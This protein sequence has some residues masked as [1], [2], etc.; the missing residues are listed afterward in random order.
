MFL[1]AV[2]VIYLL[3]FTAAEYYVCL[4]HNVLVYIYDVNKS[5]IPNKN[6][7]TIINEK[8]ITK[9]TPQYRKYTVSCIAITLP[10][11][12]Y[13]IRDF[14]QVFLWCP[15]IFIFRFVRVFIF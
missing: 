11:L 14:V 5:C 15:V 1:A 9:T 7:I 8:I 13:L 10:L 12:S 6:S 2:A 4:L 3:I